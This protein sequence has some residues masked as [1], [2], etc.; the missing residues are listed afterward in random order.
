MR[1]ILLADDNITVQRVI[2]LTF[3]GDKTIQVVTVADGQQAMEKMAASR[4]DIVLAGTTLPQISGYDLA[5]FMRGK[6]ELQRVPVLLLSGAFETVDEARL[7]SC[8]ADGVLEKPVE[9]TV[10]IN[11]VKELLGLKSDE[12]PAPAGRLSTP[13]SPVV[14]RKPPAAATTPAVTPT[15]LTPAKLEELR[16][17]SAAELRKQSASEAKA[18]PVGQQASGAKDYLDSLDAAFDT[19][20]QQ[21][22]GRVASTKTPRNPAGPIGPSGGAADPRS[23]GR[24]PS[25]GNSPSG[26]PVFEVDDDWFGSAES[27][28]RA[29]RREITEDLR[30]PEFQGPPKVPAPT[31]SSVFEVDDDWF[32]EDN[33]ARAERQLER[34]QL[35]K[36]MGIHDVD[37]PEVESPIGGS[38]PASDFDF[39]LDDFKPASAKAPGLAPQALQA[40]Q[41]VKIAPS[42]PPQAAASV[43]APDEISEAMLDQIASR[44]TQ[45][46]SSSAFAD[47][48]K[49]SILA[50][51]RDSVS[52]AIAEASERLVGAAVPAAVSETSERLIRDAVPGVVAET[53]E[54]LVRDAVKGVVT[55][56][57]ERLVRDAVPGVVAETSE[58]FVRD[59]VRGVIA[60]TS[61]RVV[62]DAVPG[63]VAE[64]SDR[65]VRDTAPGLVA[66]ATERFV[67]DTVPAVVAESSERVVRESVELAVWEAS[68]R[69]VRESVQGV[70]AEASERLVRESAPSVVAEASERFVRDSAP[71]VISDLSERL[72]RDTVP[73]VVTEISER[74]VRDSIPTIVA[75]T[76]DRL[77]RDSV[78]VAVSEASE[79]LVKDRVHEAVTAASERLVRDSVPG[80]VSETSE[81]LVR[82]T[83]R[84]VVSETSERLVREEIERI[85][86][87]NKK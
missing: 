7:G 51:M 54:R 63:V 87:K 18:A 71:A 24:G 83:L 1:T 38:A 46:L 45:R 13:A 22:S 5:K 23:P 37:L 84:A 28:A 44:V 11:R 49:D 85:K 81:R 16:K 80:A 57:S 21:L 75:E 14:E 6:A 56:T 20:D 12:T 50:A 73:A 82:E 2:A 33:K 35:A 62:R 48:L 29:G 41:A 26:N 19:L 9:P 76:S 47:Q 69:V 79:R 42:V 25:S 52:G 53:S 3:A 15:P 32:A 61:E 74:M 27:Q 34:Q 70:V 31:S 65:F 40:P 60:E 68:D 86:S 30:D 67:R 72:V 17:Q 10:V 55:E 58:R 8:G 78:H 43:K 39:G 36:E 4:P 59:A 77:V 66:Q 64:T